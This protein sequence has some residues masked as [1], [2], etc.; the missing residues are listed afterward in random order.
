M[1]HSFDLYRELEKK[2]KLST[3]TVDE[4]IKQCTDFI[5]SQKPFNISNTH[6][7][8]SAY[9]L[10]G[11]ILYENKKFDDALKCYRKQGESMSRI[12][13]SKCTAIISANL[14]LAKA[15]HNIGKALLSQGEFDEAKLNFISS[16]DFDDRT[17][18][19]RTD[20]S[21]TTDNYNNRLKIFF[22]N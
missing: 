12:F 9:G 14:K 11:D 18:S 1:K 17:V 22:V 15:H 16:W 21:E 6:E 13:T 5:D 20:K 2:I 19:A 3:S 10:W 7:V 8:S 4:K